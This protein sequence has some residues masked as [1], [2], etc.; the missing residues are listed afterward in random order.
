[1]Y[2]IIGAD[3]KQYG[4]ISIEQMRQWIAD[5]GSMRRLVCKKPMPRN[6]RRRLI[7]WSSDSHPPRVFRVWVHHLW[8]QKRH[9]P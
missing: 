5:G 4:P 6:G 8:W 3:G 7:F 1:M 2:K 9:L